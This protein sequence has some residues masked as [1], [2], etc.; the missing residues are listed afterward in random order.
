MYSDKFKE[1]KATNQNYQ[2]TGQAIPIVTGTLGG[3]VAG[4]KFAG[5]YGAVGGALVGLG[6]SA[7]KVHTNFDNM[8]NSP[9]SIKLKGQQIAIDNKVKNKFF[10]IEH[11]TLR[12][13]DLI[14]AN[15]YFYEYGYNISEI[16]N[17]S[18]F[19][20]RSSFNYIQLEDCEK[21]VH[22]LINKNVLDI[23]IKALNNGVR[24]WTKSHYETNKFKYTTNNLETKLL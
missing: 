16:D 7:L 20:T 10:N 6:T 23:I 4:A 14:Q 21:D 12:E 1:Y 13:T 8:K 2:I 15:L 19:F 9:N 5:V 18:N 11:N 22:A 24:F 17:I 3:T